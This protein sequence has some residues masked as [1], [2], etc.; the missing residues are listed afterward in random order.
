MHGL[1]RDLLMQQ[2]AATGIP[3]TTI[4]LPEEPSMDEYENGMKAAVDHLRREKFTCAGFGDIF[5]EDLRS[6][7]RKATRSAW[8]P[9]GIP[10][11]EKRH[12]GNDERIF[13]PWV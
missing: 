10:A 13:A 12:R 3:V 2:A 5:L 6:L 11:L 7:A 9:N 4:E 1:R 8:D